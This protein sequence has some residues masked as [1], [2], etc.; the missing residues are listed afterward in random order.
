MFGEPIVEETDP[1]SESARQVRER[2][3]K[4]QNRIFA[5]ALVVCSATDSSSTTSTGSAQ[6]LWQVS[7][8]PIDDKLLGHDSFQ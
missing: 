2:Q 6:Q 5:V 4:A 8:T 7:I 3:T 1:R